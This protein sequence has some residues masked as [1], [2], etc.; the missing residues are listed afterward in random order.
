MLNNGHIAVSNDELA[1]IRD[2]MRNLNRIVD[3]LNSG[4]ADKVVLT[5]G[6]KMRAVI[7]SL[8]EYERLNRG[9]R[10]LPMLGDVQ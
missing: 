6:G 1:T 5:K 7:L 8:D 10:R 4:A 9:P 3:A 2:A